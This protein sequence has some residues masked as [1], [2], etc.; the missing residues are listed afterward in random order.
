M[1]KFFLLAA[2]ALMANA[3]TL[4]SGTAFA[5]DTL[6][7]LE[8]AGEQRM[9]TRDIFLPTAPANSF[10]HKKLI[11][12]NL[13]SRSTNEKVGEITDLVIDKDGLIAA[14]IVEVGGFLGRGA[15]EVAISWDAIRRSSNRDSDGYYFS[16]SSETIQRRSNTEGAGP[17]FSVDTTTDALH[18]APEYKIVSVNY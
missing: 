3:V 4:G 18:E 13:H 9:M 12:A 14:A 1:T 11:G 8:N 10:G 7:G 2:F 16:V 6:A 5:S 15:K 17:H